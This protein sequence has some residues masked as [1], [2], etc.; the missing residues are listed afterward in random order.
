MPST[1]PSE[2]RQSLHVKYSGNSLWLAFIH[3]SFAHYATA[4]RREE[5]IGRK[6]GREGRRRRERREGMGVGR[7]EKSR[8]EEGRE[9]V[10]REGDR[11]RREGTV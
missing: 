10:G 3:Y 7:E 8:S 9:G 2:P 11:V 5:G 4:G 6:A 1:I